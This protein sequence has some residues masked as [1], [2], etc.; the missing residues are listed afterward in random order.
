MSGNHGNVELQQIRYVIAVAEEHS[1]TRAAQRCH[2]VQSALS[3]QIKALERELSV[4]LFARSSRKVELTAAGEAF[5]PG[6]YKALE[7]VERA[8][9]DSAAVDGE[10]RGSLKIGVI[11]TVTTIDVPALLSEFH[12]A[13]P[14]VR[15]RLCEGGSFDFIEAIQKGSMD[16]AILG[17]PDSMPPKGVEATV[18]AHERLHAVV[19]SEHRFAGESALRIEDLA[20]ETFV[21]FPEGTPGR[22][23]TDLAFHNVGLRREVYFEA[24]T[25]DRILGLVRANLAIA[26]LSPDAIPDTRGLSTISVSDGPT[27]IEY[28]AWSNFNPSPAANAFLSHT[29]KLRCSG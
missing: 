25:T 24:M 22:V 4:A 21:D 7:S 8:V 9:A 20:G 10:I 28:L 14:G 1:F 12:L 17:L 15:I 26:L 13:H 29:Q 11:P 3:H 19:S 2:V 6:A 16:V 23:P 18:L 27:R 5:L